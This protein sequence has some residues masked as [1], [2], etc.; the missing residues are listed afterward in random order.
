[1]CGIFG[2][3]SNNEVAPKIVLALYDLQT[4]GEQACGVF[5]SS[6]GEFNEHR[7]AGLVTEVFNKRD[8][9]GLFGKLRGRFGIGHTLYSTIGR[10]GEE[11][12]PKMFQPLIGKFYGQPFALGHNGNLIE[13]EGLRQEAEEKGYHFQSKV[14]DTEVIVALLATSPEKE[15][16]EALLKVL[17][18]LKGA[19]SLTILFKDKVIGVRDRFGIRP[20]CLG[21][22]ES[23]FMLASE[24]CAFYTPG[25]EFVREIQPGEIIILGKNGIENSSLWFG[26][27][28]LK[29]CIFEFIYFARP[30]S[31]IADRSIYSYRKNAGEILAQECPVKADI[32]IA[33]PESGRIYD[34][35]FSQATG[36]PLEIGLFRNRYFAERTFL[37]SRETDRRSL[38]W[39][40][41]HALREIVHGKRVCSLEDSIIRANVSPETASMLR[42]AGAIEV[43]E[44]VGSPPIRWPCFL[45]I[46][47]ATRIELAAADLSVEEIGRKIIHV[48]SLGYLSIEGAV[49]ASGLLKENLCLG[50]F[51]GEYPVEPPQNTDFKPPS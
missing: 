23:S 31:R 24:S 15:F 26:N 44:R 19:F 50:C 37:T 38:Q 43:H 39:I 33:V 3:V 36:I 22:D 48:D 46:D 14:S 35:A 30:D 6:G 51:T 32:I 27:P 17:P 18:R 42:K 1:M 10:G 47:M 41:M 25:A 34:I 12:Q 45:G 9:E 49:R 16:I 20:L 5:T 4:R 13:L 28:Q 7:D 40:K 2:I 21:R 11:K 29:I 8:R